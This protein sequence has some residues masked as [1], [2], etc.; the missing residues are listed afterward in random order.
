LGSHAVP[1]NLGRTHSCTGEYVRFKLCQTLILRH[2]DIPKHKGGLAWDL[3]PY[4]GCL[5]FYRNIFK[6]SLCFIYKS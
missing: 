6:I 4:F 5:S 3:N 2:F 1:L